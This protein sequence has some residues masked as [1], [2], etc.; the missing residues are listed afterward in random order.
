MSDHTPS[1]KDP[2]TDPVEEV[3]SSMPIV[4]P[5]VGAVMMPIFEPA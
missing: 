1:S 3:V 5:L 4:L 2:V